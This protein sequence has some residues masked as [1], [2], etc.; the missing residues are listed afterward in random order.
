MRFKLP[1]IEDD[2]IFRR[3]CLQLANTWGHLLIWGE[4]CAIEREDGKG[5]FGTGTCVAAMA[6]TLG[7]A[8]FQN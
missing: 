6:H 8:K 3:G 1:F 5:I 4:Y 7:V 2:G